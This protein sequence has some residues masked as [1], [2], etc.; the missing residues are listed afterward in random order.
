[1]RKVNKK[2]EVLDELYAKYESATGTGELA[3]SIPTNYYKSTTIKILE[4]IKLRAGAGVKNMKQMIK[5]IDV[6]I[7][8]I[9]KLERVKSE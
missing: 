4:S 2:K 9:K 3:E 8:E 7:S 1:M 6:S 5:D